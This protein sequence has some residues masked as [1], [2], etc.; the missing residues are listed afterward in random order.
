MQA[1]VLSVRTSYNQAIEGREPG[2]PDCSSDF[3]ENP[4]VPKQKAGVS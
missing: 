4:G 2:S 3:N 1:F